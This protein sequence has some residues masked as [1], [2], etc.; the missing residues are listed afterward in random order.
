[1]KIKITYKDNEE[2]NIVAV[3]VNGQEVEWFYFILKELVSENES[4]SKIFE[5]DYENDSLYL[6][7]KEINKSYF[8]LYDFKIKGASLENLQKHINEAVGQI[9]K[10]IN[11]PTKTKEFYITL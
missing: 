7:D 1:M 11:I 2:K 9:K 5:I 4:I 10:I 6:Y 3:E 8:L